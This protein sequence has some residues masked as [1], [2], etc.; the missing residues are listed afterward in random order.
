MT[1]R[2][3]DDPRDLA[4]QQRATAEDRRRDRALRRAGQGR[5]RAGDR[6]R[7][8]GEQWPE[9]LRD[10]TAVVVECDEHTFGDGSYEVTVRRDGYRHTV[11]RWNSLSCALVGQAQSAD[12]GEPD[13][14]Q[15]RRVLP[16]SP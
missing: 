4:R 13:V 2:G 16:D 10:G 12:D 11:W 6:V 7:H 3:S 8:Y 15:E 9:A 14:E 5:F 1:D